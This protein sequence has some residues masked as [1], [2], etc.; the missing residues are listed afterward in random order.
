MNL[1]ASDYYETLGVGRN[2][3]D[4]EL[5]RAYRKLAMQHHPDR[6][7]GDEA[8]ERRFKEASEAYAVLSDAQKRSQYDRF[9]RVEGLGESGFPFGGGGSSFGGFRD[10]FGDIFEDFFGGT[11][12]GHGSE[13]MRGGA[14]L[15]YNMEITFEQAAFGAETEIRIPRLESCKK[16][17]GS[18][19]RTP[20]DLEAC[21]HCQGSGQ[22]RMQ[23]GFFSVA[24]TCRRCNGSGRR[25]RSACTV[26]RGQGRTQETRRL[27]V[28]I[29]PGVED[30][31]RIKLNGEGEHGAEGGPPGDLYIVLSVLEHPFFER[32]GMNLLCHIPIAFTQAALGAEIM[33]PTLRG[34][35]ELKIPAG[36][37]SGC[38]FRMKGR[39]LPQLGM[40]GRTGDQ[41]VRLDVEVPELLS[42]QQRK[43]L[44]EFQS[45]D[46]VQERRYPARYRFQQSF[47]R[48]FGN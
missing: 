28:R 10:I 48:L 2:A 1:A 12:A 46:E 21:S 39:G 23:Q 6:N 38:I 35:A 37:Q 18:G 9:G 22:Q 32:E 42:R 3:N 30:H 8:A 15:Q 47:R 11:A 19:A 14:N 33:V 25:I 4:E 34:K 31:T 29:P 40:G 20:Q 16:C 24:T 41:L 17:G 43:L 44:E 45:S 36:T 5:K 26:C 13:R 7:P 27:K